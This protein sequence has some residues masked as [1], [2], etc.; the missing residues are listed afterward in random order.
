MKAKLS[1]FPLKQAISKKW[2]PKPA[3]MKWA[4]NAIIKYGLLY[5]AIVWGI[6][7]RHKTR[8]DRLNKLNF[9]AVSLL[10]NTRRC[11][12]R[13]LQEV[14]HDPC[15]SYA[16]SCFFWFFVLKFKLHHQVAA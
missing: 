1:L 4:Y 3:Y 15:R 9:L 8:N 11:T 13:K 7:I 14:M 10:G 6:A 2:R 5:G 12:L 16:T